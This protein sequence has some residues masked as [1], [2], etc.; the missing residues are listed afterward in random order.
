MQFTIQIQPATHGLFRIAIPEANL[1]IYRPL[2]PP[3]CQGD[4]PVWDDGDVAVF[5]EARH[6]GPHPAFDVRLVLRQGGAQQAASPDA[7]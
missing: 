7:A 5:V 1:A 6:A 3:D 2:T 4:A